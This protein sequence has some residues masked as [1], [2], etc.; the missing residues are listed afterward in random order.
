ML[1]LSEQVR[2]DFSVQ[3]RLGN[4]G[5]VFLCLTT[6]R[7]WE[8]K[9]E[10][11]AAVVAISLIFIAAQPTFFPRTLSSSA[12]PFRDSNPA[13]SLRWLRSTGLPFTKNTV[14]NFFAMT[15]RKPLSICLWPNAAK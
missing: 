11:V 15:L 6:Q 13:I 4:T 3:L 1:L 8:K 5:F 9:F 14:G 12:L 10:L 7:P 2:P